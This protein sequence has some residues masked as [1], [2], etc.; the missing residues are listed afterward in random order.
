MMTSSD[1]V[2]ISLRQVLRQRSYGVICSIALG[3][4]AFVTLSVLGRE[5]RYNIGQDMVLLGGVNVI[6][7]FLDYGK[8]PGS[9]RQEFLPESVEAIRSLPG[10]LLAGR[11]TWDI[12]VYRT[13][14]GERSVSMTMT[15]VDE[16][17]WDIYAATLQTGRFFTAEDVK[18]RRRVCLLGKEL[19][20]DIFGDANPI[21]EP[22]FLGSEAFEV[23]GTFGGVMMGEWVR[24]GFMP[25]TTAVDRNFSEGLVNRIFV[26][27]VAWED[28]SRLIR[29]IPQVIAQHQKVNHLVIRTQDEQLVRVQTIF[30]WVEAL[31]WLGIAA[32]LMLGGFGIW[33]G[34][35]AAVRARTREVGLKKAMGGADA[36]IL[37]Q[38]LTEALCKSIAGGLLGIVLGTVIVEVGSLM[39]SCSVSYGLLAASSVGSIVFSAFIG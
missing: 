15:G 4:M 2:R 32:S 12:K 34:T 17:F 9:P 18:E 5:I 3:I 11:N 35:F 38:F 8:F 36:D 21:G 23:I 20:R 1:L 22:V 26:R 31:L 6:S 14:V 33:Y 13:R 7:V 19:A 39:L 25:Y 29:E 28:V 27:A 10:V 37:A 30:V 24:W 16:H